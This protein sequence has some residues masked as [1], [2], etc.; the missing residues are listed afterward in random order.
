MLENGST[1]AL[2]TRP[3]PHPDLSAFPWPIGSTLFNRIIHRLSRLETIEVSE[4]P[5]RSILVKFVTNI[6]QDHVKFSEFQFHRKIFGLVCIGQSTSSNT[7]LPKTG[8]EH[9]HSQTLSGNSDAAEVSRS[10]HSSTNA[11]SLDTI[12]EQY[13]AKKAEFKSMLVDN[14]CVYL[15]FLIRRA[16]LSLSKRLDL[17]FEKMDTPPCPLLPEEEKYRMGTENMKSKLYRRKCIGRLRKQVADHALLTGLPTLAM[18]AYH[19]A[20]EYLELASDFLWLAAA[21]EDKRRVS[22]VATT[23]DLQDLASQHQTGVS[24]GHQRY[25]SDEGYFPCSIA[26]TSNY[27]SLPTSDAAAQDDNSV[28][29]KQSWENNNLQPPGNTSKFL[30]VPHSST[31]SLVSSTSFGRR[32]GVQAPRISVPPLVL[33][34]FLCKWGCGRQV[35][36][37]GPSL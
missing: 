22:G 29:K 30:N 5:K 20:V 32:P 16:V 6:T 25:R 13:S 3:L 4:N 12:K 10:T 15:D 14:R 19:S 24:I 18:D 34:L 1:I 2:S 8:G 17:S 9:D 35:G 31:A 36:F 37:P 27:Q 11:N 26:S 21:L 33:H 7:Y 23:S 28:A